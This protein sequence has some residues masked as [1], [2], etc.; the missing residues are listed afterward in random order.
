MAWFSIPV[1]NAGVHV[2]LCMECMECRAA[3]ILWTLCQIAVKA[4]S[5]RVID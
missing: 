4:W 2:V 5:N 3:E 1:L